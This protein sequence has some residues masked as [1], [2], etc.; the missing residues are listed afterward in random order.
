MSN[1]KFCHNPLTAINLSDIEPDCCQGC[2]TN[3]INKLEPIEED[4]EISTLC[5]E[6]LNTIS[7]TLFPTPM[8][9]TDKM[10]R[11]NSQHDKMY[12]N[13]GWWNRR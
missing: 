7:K 4:K 3:L 2:E 5:D 8:Y 12:R 6:D 11:K 10:V 1:C 13:D 9:L